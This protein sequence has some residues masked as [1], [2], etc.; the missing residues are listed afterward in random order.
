MSRIYLTGDIHGDPRRLSMLGFPEQK[1][2]TKEDY[3]II[4]GDFG[5]VWDNVESREE[6]YWLNWLNDKPFTTLFIDGNHENFDRLNSYPVETWNGGK[7]Q[8]IRPSV[9]HLIRGQIFNIDGCKIFTFGGAKSHDIKDGILEIG[10][11]KI[12]Q[13]SKDYTKLFRINKLSWWEQELP[14]NDELSEALSNLEKANY[15]VDFVLTHCTSTSSA[16]LLGG[17]K[18]NDVLTNFFENIRPKLNFKRWYFGH[19]HMDKAINTKEI[20]MYEKIERIY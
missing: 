18:D 9:Y 10:D 7:I 8:K 1:E 11:P 16:I 15:D 13:W 6:K 17:F 14:S 12:K 19:Y 3:V 4:L 20:C 5:L 2:L